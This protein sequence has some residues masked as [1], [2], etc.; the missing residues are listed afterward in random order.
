MMNHRDRIEKAIHRE[1]VDSI[2]VAFWRHFPVDDQN[3]QSLAKSTLA[4]QELFDF[5]LIKVTPSSSFCLMDWGAR[6]VW[7]GNPE[8]TRDY[9]EPVIKKPED[10]ES[11]KLLDPQKGY[12]GRQLECLKMIKS[13]VNGDTPIIQSIFSPL[14]QAKNLAGKSD[15]Q[16]HLRNY[17]DNF[18]VGL[19]IITK[20]TA[21]FIEECIKIGIDGLFFAVQHAS[22]DLLSEE[23]FI[24]FG[25]Y[26]DSKLFELMGSFWLNML[27]IHGKNIMFDAVSEYPVQIVNWHDRETDPALKTGKANSKGAVCGGVGRIDSMVLGDSQNIKN[28]IDDAIQKTDGTGLIIG[29]GCVLPQ[30]TPLGNIFTAVEY[31]RSISTING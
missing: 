31:S 19:D 17:S 28:E 8:G 18:K 12:L 1:R 6:D 4:F 25:K 29:T 15:L 27:H 20:T 5:D 23:E 10:W 30:T 26:Y 9:L 7:Q 2:P 21:R 13:R 16:Y 3:A 24:I 11:L 14:A 22:Y